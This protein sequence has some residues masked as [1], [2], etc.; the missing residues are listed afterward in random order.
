[1]ADDRPHRAAFMHMMVN[2]AE[3]RPFVIGYLMPHIADELLCGA[4]RAW[5][6][7]QAKVAD[8]EAE[9]HALPDREI[10]DTRD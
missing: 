10:Y 4:I 8:L 5:R 7:H 1:M 2:E 3:C 6:D 9:R